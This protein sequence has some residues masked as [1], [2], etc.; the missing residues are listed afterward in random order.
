MVIKEDEGIEGYRQKISGL[1]REILALVKKREEWSLA[2]DR[3]KRSLSLPQRDFAREK[4]VFENAKATAQELGLPLDFAVSLQKL[5]LEDS[6]SRQ[7]QDRIENSFLGQKSV[8]VI[9]GSGRLGSW[10]CRFFADCGHRI[11]VVDPVR[12]Q[13]ACSYATSF[14]E[15]ADLYDLIVVATPIR[16]SIEILEKILTI[17]LKKPVIFDVS[18]VKNPVQRILIDLKNSGANVT[19]LHPM[20]GPS[21]QLL[22]GKH[23]VRCSLGV[24]QAD[25]LVNELFASTSLQVV[26]MSIDEHDEIISLLLALTHAFCITFAHALNKSSFTATALEKFSSPT[27]ANLLAISKKVMNENPHLYYE[28]QALNPHTERAHALLQGSLSD[29]ITSIKKLDEDAFVDI[30][31]RAQQYVGT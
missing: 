12:P 18:S 30:M 9:G 10:L 17:K 11:S 4:T 2:I 25:S 26:D 22:F 15:S 31:K 27:F 16:A 3:K 24:A 19:S 1:D 28:I 13:F 14:D 20:F 7:E 5:I 21:V 23:I 29:V 6:L 8:L